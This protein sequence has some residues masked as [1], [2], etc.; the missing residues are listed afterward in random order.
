MGSSS[1]PGV[2]PFSPKA[3]FTLAHLTFSAVENCFA[4]LSCKVAAPADVCQEGA[5]TP[6]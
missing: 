1:I 5:E 3:G 6:L 4:L 2:V